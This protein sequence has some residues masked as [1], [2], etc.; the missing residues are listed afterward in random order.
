MSLTN[1]LPDSDWLKEGGWFTTPCNVDPNNPEEDPG[2]SWEILDSEA[3]AFHWLLVS[4][5]PFL[6]W[7][8]E[9]HVDRVLPQGPLNCPSPSQ[10]PHHSEHQHQWPQPQS[11]L[12]R[13]AWRTTPITAKAARPPQHCNPHFKDE[14]WG[15][16]PSSLSYLKP[17]TS[18]MNWCKN[19]RGRR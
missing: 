7:R 13:T 8:K 3:T 15:G 6:S 12:L 11:G 4:R 9:S 18:S 10:Q 2:S 1:N 16:G 17:H 14:E 5:D 19:E